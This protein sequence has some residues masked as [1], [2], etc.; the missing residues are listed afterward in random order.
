[1]PSKSHH[2]AVAII[3]PQEVWEPIQA[4]RRVH[5]RQY[6]R[7]MPH[8]NLLYPF[9][10]VEQF[11]E[12][13]PR[14]E[15]ACSHVTAFPVTLAEFRMFVHP[16]GRATLWL[17]PEPK[18][19]LVDLQAALVAAVP[20][21]DD[22]SRFAAGFTPHLSVGQARSRREAE[23]LLADLRAAWQ[24]IHFHVSAVA[25]I[26]RDADTPFR[27]EHCVELAAIG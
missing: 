21:C 3:P 18:T 22:L 15:T 25:L 20:D 2:T 5:D 10:P 27:I 9:L 24:P 1:M 8:I 14:L 19:P 17:A 23:R 16:S 12:V 4:I 11:A 7:W 26:R 13:L 6:Q